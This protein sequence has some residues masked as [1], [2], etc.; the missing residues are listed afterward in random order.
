MEI[1]ILLLLILVNGLFALAEMCVVSSRKTR[2]RQLANEG[3]Q[4]ATRALE[5]STHPD[6]FLSTTQIGIT[7]IGILAG[8]FGERALVAHLSSHLQQYSQIAPYSESVAF[9]IV[10][11]GITYVTLV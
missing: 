10:V 4:G 3:V 9:G 7:L 1:L 5:L 2:L 6:R 8:A 11:V